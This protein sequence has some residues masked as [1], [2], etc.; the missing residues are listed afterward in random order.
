MGYGSTGRFME[1]A[2]IFDN[3]G[4]KPG[5]SIC[6]LGDQ[7]V[8]ITGKD[9]LYYIKMFIEHYAGIY[10]PKKYED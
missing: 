3:N 2:Y 7:T 9:V 5:A 10:N 6:A 8:R 4:I 1:H